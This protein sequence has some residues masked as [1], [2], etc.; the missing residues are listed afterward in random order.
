MALRRIIM[1]IAIAAL[2]PACGTSTS[3][4]S[5]KATD[6]TGA[7]DM[8][9]MTGTSKASGPA[10]TKL[11]T[12]P[13]LVEDYACGN[14]GKKVL[15][16]HVPKGNPENKHTICISYNAVKAHLKHGDEMDYLGSCDAAGGGDDGSGGDGSGGGGDDGS[17]GTP[18]DD[19]GG[20]P[21]DDGG[22][23]PPDDGGEP[24]AFCQ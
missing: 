6:T 20:T 5:E 10:L 18:P 1:G 24:C 7:S 4:T 19:G 14:N 23:T 3:N 16:C 17:G 12:H 21:P 2:L 9:D 11:C 15:V 13:E 22:G 8:F